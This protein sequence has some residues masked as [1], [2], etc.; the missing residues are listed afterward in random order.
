MDLSE[1]LM[2]LHALRLQRFRFVL[3]PGP[4]AACHTVLK[5][6]LAALR[7]LSR[8]GGTAPDEPEAIEVCAEAMALV[9]ETALR[10]AATGG[11]ALFV[12]YGQDGPYESSLNALRDHRAVDPLEV[13]ELPVCPPLTACCCAPRPGGHRVVP[14][15]APRP[16]LRCGPPGVHCTAAREAE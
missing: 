9:E 13:R 5:R 16:S 10:I 8:D 7:A 6:R 4:T 2:P 14:A 3:S 12:D 15:S 1:L 11:L